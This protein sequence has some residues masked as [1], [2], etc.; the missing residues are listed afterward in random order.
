MD[1]RP[2]FALMAAV[3]LACA[4]AACGD[5]DNPA[6]P[7]DTTPPGVSTVTPVDDH[8]IDITFSEQVTKSSA[9]DESNY[10]ITPAPIPVSPKGGAAAAGGIT[11]A[12]ATLKGDNKTVTLATDQSMAGLNLQVTVHDV[13]D[14]TG[15]KIG[16]GGSGKSF[17]GSNTTDET[18]PSVVSKAPVANAT[19]IAV[20]ATVV[21][22]FSEAIQSASAQWFAGPG[23]GA[24]SGSARGGVSFA[25]EIDGSKLTL[26]L[27]A[28][29]AY[30]QLYTVTVNAD[31]FAGNPSGTT[32]WSFTTT[33]NNDHTPPTLVSTVP[34]NLA[35][36]VD[37]NTDLSLT[38]SETINQSDFNV[39]LAP[40]AGDGV[41]TWS[42]DGKTVTFNPAAPLTD[43]TQYT[44]SIFPQGVF[45]LAGNGIV[46]IHTVQFTTAATLAAGSI[47]GTVTG[48]AGTPAADPTGAT[49]IAADGSP[50]GG[51]F[52]VFGSVKVAANNTYNV[53]YLPDGT[54]YIVSVM[55]T[56]H[57]GDLD[58]SSGD[59]VGGYG[60]DVGGGDLDPD[61]V[62]VAG[63]AHV[64]GKNFALY[65][66]TTASG[67][68][69]Y[70]GSANGDYPVYIGFFDTNGFSITDDPL[71]ATDAFGIDHEWLFNSA[72]GALDGP[73]VEGNYYVGAFMDVNNSGFFE[74]ATDPAGFYGGLPTPTV[75]NLA[76]GAD[77]TN[78]VIPIQDPVPGLV[79]TAP[80]LW[81]KAKHNAAFQRLV[82][83]VRQSQQQAS[84]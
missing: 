81:P 35:A 25:Q 44:F 1:I 49:V 12:G 62:A 64:T 11:V 7:N 47:G 40:D 48:D 13:S 19:N 45:D 24:A 22:N 27:N 61:S 26:T 38:F 52:N 29:L 23:A 50:F 63:G 46:G 37:V 53:L 76:N 9:E 28:P 14:M 2:R 51:L 54:Y 60:A 30:S 58:P 59:A 67:T 42:E 6:T 16:E 71:A 73:F 8:H 36:G 82:D 32:Q 21:V 43:D 79:V 75:V 74:P 65:D 33:A 78:I 15:N 69:T 4:L 57:D 20:N 18:A 39:E 77:R 80:V 68:V 72:D 5:D 41:A 70:S 17:T 66:P 55:D 84:R 3:L 34:A 83:I 31:D 56:N 10:A